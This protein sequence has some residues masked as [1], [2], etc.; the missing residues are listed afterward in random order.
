MKS[1]E[2]N[3]KEARNHL[4]ALLDKVSNGEEVILL[5]RG[6]RIAHLI[7]PKK[8]K[9]KL[10]SLK[11]F[12]ASISVLGKPLSRQVLEERNETRY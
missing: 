10:P 7:F 12:R 11:A 1:L 5:R 8:R 3:V 4:S 6:K 9:T 2:I